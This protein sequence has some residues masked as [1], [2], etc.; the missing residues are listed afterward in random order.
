MKRKDEMADFAGFLGCA[1]CFA[2]LG[3]AAA[4]PHKVVML[5]TDATAWIGGM[6]A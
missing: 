3:Y 5:L 2:F 6:L 4:V 1:A